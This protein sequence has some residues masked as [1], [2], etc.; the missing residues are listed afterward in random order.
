MVCLDD[1]FLAVANVQAD[2]LKKRGGNLE[3]GIPWR[4]GEQAHGGSHIGGSHRAGVIIHP[5]QV[6]RRLQLIE[7]LLG[8]AGAGIAAGK[9]F[10]SINLPRPVLRPRWP[11]H[12]IKQ[13]WGMHINLIVAGMEHTGAIFRVIFP[14]QV[15]KLPIHGVLA[16]HQIHQACHVIG[17]PEGILPQGTLVQPLPAANGF[18]V[19]AQPGAVCIFPPQKAHRLRADRLLSHADHLLVLGSRDHGVRPVQLLVEKGAHGVFLVVFPVFLIAGL[20]IQHICQQGN[21]PVVIAVFHHPVC[22]SAAVCL[23]YPVRNVLRLLI[24]RR[25]VGDIRHPLRHAVRQKRHRMFC[26]DIRHHLEIMAPGGKP[27]L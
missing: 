5:I 21:C 14:H 18:R 20:G 3:R 19:P 13:V 26:A 23:C 7:V 16:A 1:K 8:A 2:F 22:P 12:I 27:G 4:Y 10:V 24:S 6:A 17:I 9:G 25:Q 11:P 15:G